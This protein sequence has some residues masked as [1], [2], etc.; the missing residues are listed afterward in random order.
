MVSS[1]RNLW[2][3]N[4]FGPDFLILYVNNKLSWP[5]I[6]D[7]KL[8]TVNSMENLKNSVSSF[9]YKFLMKYSSHLL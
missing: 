2:E 9:V 4:I 8:G 3:H 6:L 7:K 5:P 1:N